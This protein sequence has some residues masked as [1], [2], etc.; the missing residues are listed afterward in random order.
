M[1]IVFPASPLIVVRRRFPDPFLFGAAA[2][3]RNI[4]ECGQHIGKRS[5]CHGFGEIAVTGQ[6]TDTAFP[7]SV[8]DKRHYRAAQMGEQ[9]QLRC[10]SENRFVQTG[11][12]PRRNIDIAVP[13]PF[14]HLRRG[15]HPSGI[16]PDDLP[17]A[18][19][20]SNVL[21]RKKRIKHLSARCGNQC[22]HIPPLL[23]VELISVSLILR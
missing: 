16:V 14:R 12:T 18:F 19:R 8:A 2:V 23:R 3:S 11:R 6:N 10:G 5:L 15:E 4:A 17:K 21:R 9:L 7:H 1:P 13:D 22:F 20:Q